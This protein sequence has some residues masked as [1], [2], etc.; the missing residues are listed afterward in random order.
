MNNELPKPWNRKLLLILDKFHKEDLSMSEDGKEL[1]RN[2]EIHVVSVD[3]FEMIKD[4]INILGNIKPSPNV[5]LTMSPYTDNSYLDISES[6]ELIPIYIANSTVK[7]CHLL[8]AKSIKFLNLKIIDKKENK[9][10]TINLN[11]SVTSVGIDIDTK[12]I[13][14]LKNKLTINTEF[15]GGEAQIENA[16]IFLKERGLAGD[17]I[18]NNLID[19]RRDANSN[20]TKNIEYEICLTE[21]LTKNL[22]IAASMRYITAGLKGSYSSLKEQTIDLYLKIEVKF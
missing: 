6:K 7:L 21:S 5:V 15:E 16:E 2:D 11:N 12:S 17:S 4:K 10:A 8:G 20:P 13:Y 1:L 9:E 3:E 19:L 18:L 22:N 14:N